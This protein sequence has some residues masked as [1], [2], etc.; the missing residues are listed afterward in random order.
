MQEHRPFFVLGQRE[1]LSSRP[2]Q[3]ASDPASPRHRAASARAQI[4]SRPS[5]DS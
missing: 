2:R 5:L 4:A 1:A 3:R